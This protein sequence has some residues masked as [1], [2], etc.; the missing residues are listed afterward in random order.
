MYV[1]ELVKEFFRYAEKKLE[2]LP[3]Q[4]QEAITEPIGKALETGWELIEQGDAI[5]AF[6]GLANQMI[7]HFLIIDREGV[8]I[9]KK[10]IA[11]SQLVPQWEF[12]LRRILSLGYV[13]GTWRLEDAE[14][15]SKQ[16]KYTF[17]KPSRQLTEKL[18]V[19]HLV[20]L[21]FEF[22]SSNEEHPRAERMWV[23]ITA[24]EDGVFKG[25][26]D[27]HPFYLHEL[28]A[29]D[30]ITFEHK[31]IVDHDMELSEPSLVDKYYDRCLVTHKVLYE[32]AAINYI[33]RE[34]PMQEDEELDY[35]DTGWRVLS[36]DET[37]EYLDDPD[38]SSF[39]SLGKVLSLD[40][41][42]IHLLDAAVGTT[43]ERNT[44]GVFEEI[45]ED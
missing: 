8:A 6:E 35:V 32:Q 36:G 24:I 19:G 43:F 38:H 25:V 37:E 16:N 22:D 3:D 21:I 18:E 1:Q 13:M 44:N 7:D 4:A 12:D 45:E 29:G 5:T 20:K 34:E 42:F 11:C 9:V 41:S 17:Y 23:L 33:Y 14:E 39:V 10:L 27:N 2:N 15:V 40:D 26:L 30:E 28:Y 31:H